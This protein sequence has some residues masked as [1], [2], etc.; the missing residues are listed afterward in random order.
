MC[1]FLSRM[2]P[3]CNGQRAWGKPSGQKGCSRL[4]T[5][6]SWGQSKPWLNRKQGA[7]GV[8]WEG[9]GVWW[10]RTFSKNQT[11]VCRMDGEERSDQ[12]GCLGG[13]YR[14]SSVSCCT[15]PQEPGRTDMAW[16]G[17]SQALASPVG[18][19]L[20][21]L[22]V[23]QETHQGLEAG[24]A[25]PWEHVPKPSTIHGREWLTLLLWIDPLKTILKCLCN[26]LL[27]FSCMSLLLCIPGNCTP[28]AFL[29]IL[30]LTW[31]ILLPVV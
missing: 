12:W 25:H 26:H 3:L 23:P 10:K 20:Q 9:E 29:F 31:I 5:L 17:H 1:P 2:G 28:D 13:C 7:S 4:Q 11:A 18:V 15:R 27:C 22:R 30:W 19:M 14:N 6:K 16:R 8:L 24:L 21:C